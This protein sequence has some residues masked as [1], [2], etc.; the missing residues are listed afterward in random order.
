M[1]VVLSLAT[2]IF[3]L[4]FIQCTK[5]MPYLYI[6]KCSNPSINNR[7]GQVLVIIQVRNIVMEEP[8][9]RLLVEDIKHISIA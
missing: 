3:R 6:T 5:I 8:K 2:W 7:Y 4:V 1:I 9:Q